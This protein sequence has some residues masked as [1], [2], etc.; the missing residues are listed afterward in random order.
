[1][2]SDLQSWAWHKI[3]R[4]CVEA[5]VKV[6]KN[7]LLPFNMFTLGKFLIYFQRFTCLSLLFWEFYWS[8]WE[9][10]VIFFRGNYLYLVVT[11]SKKIAVCTHYICIIL[12][13]NWNSCHGNKNTN[14]III[15]ILAN[16]YSLCLTCYL[17]SYLSESDI[18]FTMQLWK[19]LNF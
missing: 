5:F 14:K 17:S 15:I 9:I 8:Y 3:S 2:Q 13:R 7:N 4:F 12:K 11:L 16:E 10:F 1:M 6:S 18:Q 19:D